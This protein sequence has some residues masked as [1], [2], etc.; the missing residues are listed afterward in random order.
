MND[1]DRSGNGPNVLGRV[2]MGETRGPEGI[3]T[4]Q[5]LADRLKVPVSWI[6]EK[7]RSRSR[8]PLPVIRL[9]RYMRFD[10][11]DVAEWI[12]RHRQAA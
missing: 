7:T 8:D 12:E 3:L 9:G 11:L 2:A 1:A 6:Y 4:P 5:E 10:W